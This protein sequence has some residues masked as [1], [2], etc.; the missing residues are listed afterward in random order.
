MPR[1]LLD[2]LHFIPTAIRRLNLKL[3]SGAK[4]VDG[5]VNARFHAQLSAK[6][7]LNGWTL[8][9]GPKRDAR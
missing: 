3:G 1:D 6:I 2:L 8:L 9:K 4:E 5:G 7:P